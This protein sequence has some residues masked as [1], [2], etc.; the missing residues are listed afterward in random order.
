MSKLSAKQQKFVTE[1]LVDLNATQAAIRA[2]YSEKTA[3][4]IGSQNLSKV[5]IQTE[6][7][8]RRGKIEKKTEITVERVLAEYGKIAFSEASETLKNQ[9]KLKALDALGRHLG[10]FVHKVEA[11]INLNKKS[12]KDELNELLF[13][14][15]SEDNDTAE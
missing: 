13:Y 6:I 5:D 11:D 8:K 9:D 15:F 1:Y 7:E 12:D 10:L 2:G 3:N 14:E 4:R